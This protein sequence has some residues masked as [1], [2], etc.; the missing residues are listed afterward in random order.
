MNFRDVLITLGQIPSPGIG[1]EFAGVVEEV[2]ADVTSVA[3]GDRVFGLGLG[4]FSTRTVTLA[5]LV[6]KILTQRT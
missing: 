5:E 4:C 2:G 1:F 6:T 3:I